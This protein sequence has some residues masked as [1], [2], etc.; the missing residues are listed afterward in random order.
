MTV[1]DFVFGVILLIVILI[2]FIS[3]LGAKYDV[4]GK[5]E[6]NKLLREELKKQLLKEI[7][8]KNKEKKIKRRTKSESIRSKSIR[9]RTVKNKSKM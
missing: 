1:L 9:R 5:N 8:N 2:M 4:L 3:W 7:K 6:E